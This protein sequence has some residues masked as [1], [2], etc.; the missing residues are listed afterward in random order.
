MFSEQWTDFCLEELQLLLT[1]TTLA[2]GF[3]QCLLCRVR[4]RPRSKQQAENEE[5]YP[6]V[7]C[8]GDNS[9]V[10]ISCFVHFQDFRIRDHGIKEDKLV[11]ASIE[12][13]YR[14]SQ[15]IAGPPP[16]A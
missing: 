16:I 11:H 12:I 7:G 15:P 6:E 8:E 13:P 2:V 10:G 3:A 14:M 4:V 9:W 1:S 5:D